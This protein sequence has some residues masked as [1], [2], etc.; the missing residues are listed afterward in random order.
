MIKQQIQI[1]K[2][3]KSRHESQILQIIKKEPD[4]E[5]ADEKYVDEYKLALESSITYVACKG[6]TVCG[7]S[8]SLNDHEMYIF[9][10]DLLVDP[11][12]RGQSLGRKL[13][14]IIYQ[15]YAVDEVYVMS[16]IDPYYEKLDY[17]HEGSIFKVTNPSTVMNEPDKTQA[18]ISLL[19][20][21]QEIPYKLLLLADESVEAINKYVHESD[22]Y[23]YQLDGEVLAVCAAMEVSLDTVEIKNV[24]VDTP[25]QGKGIGSLL[26]R[27]VIEQTRAKGYQRITIG[28][29]DAGFKQIKLYHKL[30]FELYDIKRN[31]ISDNYPEPIYED[32]IQLRDMVMLKM[33]LG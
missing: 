29:G 25:H 9:V 4:W 31:F 5:Y 14:E 12:Y 3:N 11:A 6:D 2:Y 19:R 7:Y 22:I 32:G 16:D 13:S 23:E 26:I 1:E 28:T 18:K 27:Y 24:A 33:E 20:A 30:G 21:D 17:K 10:C 8:R 15:D